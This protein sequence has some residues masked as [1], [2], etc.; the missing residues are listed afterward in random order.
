MLEFL[1]ENYFMPLY[2]V[3]LAISVYRYRWYYDGI[4][5]YFPIIL[6][7]TLLS[8]ILGYLVHEFDHFQI[9]GS[10]QYHYANNLIFNIYDIVFFLYFYYIFWKVIQKASYKSSVKIGAI[11]YLVSIVINTFLENALIF[12]QVYASTIGSVILVMC[13]VLYF[14]EIKSQELEINSLLVWVSVGLLIFNLL[15]PPIMIMGHFEY[16]AYKKLHLRQLHYLLIV[17][18]YSSICIGLIT[19]GRTKSVRETY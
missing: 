4:L 6:G 7:Y 9:V 16:E 17:A 2:V 15:F 14:K 13:I 8:E 12:P 19:L 18:M 5:K 10:E 1:K 11:I 3:T